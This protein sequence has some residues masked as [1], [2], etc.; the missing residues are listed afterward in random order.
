MPKSYTFPLLFI[1]ILL[2]LVATTVQ[3][4]PYQSV[5]VYNNGEA[6]SRWFGF[7]V[8]NTRLCVCLSKTQTYRIQ[9]DNA[10]DVKLF[11]STDCT[12]S[13]GT[14]GSTTNIY[15]AQ[16]VNSVSWGKKGIPSQGLDKGCVN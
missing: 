4:D 1:T 10:G 9:T 14:M 16:W 12:G 3:A 6:K 5:I 8:P 2:L 15:N 13:Y 7:D 11:G